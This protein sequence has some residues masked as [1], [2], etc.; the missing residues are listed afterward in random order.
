[1]IFEKKNIETITISVISILIATYL[2]PFLASV[3]GDIIFNASINFT[4]FNNYLYQRVATRNYNIDKFI[5]L[6]L[7]NISIIIL[8]YI[9]LNY[10]KSVNNLLNIIG[11]YN[12]K[13]MIDGS[14]E[15]VD[16]NNKKLIKKKEVEKEIIYK[17]EELEQKRIKI[18]KYSIRDKLIFYIALFIYIF[19]GVMVL[20]T[21]TAIESKVN[22]FENTKRI[23]SP[24]L[25][26]NEIRRIESNFVLIKNENDYNDLLNYM[27][28]ILIENGKMI[29]WQKNRTALN[30]R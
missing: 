5:Y 1:M 16:K 25:T 20:S 26:E 24:Y 21:E 2:I 17:K 19:V 15:N 10:K 28:K 27:N 29:L 8:I 18:N 9:F 11:E 14:K 12:S 4:E 30:K 6:F 23:V 22:K 7:F 3:F 13:L